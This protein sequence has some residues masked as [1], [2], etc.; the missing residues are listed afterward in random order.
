MMIGEGVHEKSSSSS[1]CGEGGA[2][3]T[4]VGART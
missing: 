4:S 2:V 3:A 1:L